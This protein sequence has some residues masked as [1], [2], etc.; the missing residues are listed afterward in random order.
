M[1]RLAAMSGAQAR[2]QSTET[3]AV[4]AQGDSTEEDAARAHA[5]TVA[6]GRFAIVRRLGEGAQ[7]TTL[8]AVDKRDGRLVAIKRFAVRGAK[9]WKDVELAE[10]EAR[11]LAS[12]SHPSLPAY[13]EHFEEDGCLYL[14]MERVDGESVRALQAGGQRFTQEDVVA[15]LNQAAD[16]L[17]YLHGHAPPIIHRDIKP[18]NVIRR[19]NGD[20]AIVD[21]GSVRD[22]LKPEGGSTV[23][24]TFGY[25]APEQF[26]GRAQPAS[27]VYAVGATAL[28]MLTARTPDQLPHHGLSI[29]VRGALSGQVAPA[30]V[31]TLVRMLE[32]NPDQRPLRLRPLLDEWGLSSQARGGAASPAPRR[33]QER[34]GLRRRQGPGWWLL[35]SPIIVTL[36]LVLLTIVSVVSWA[37]LQVALPL[38]FTVLSVVLGRRARYAARAAG[39]A[40]KRTRRALARA[41]RAVREQADAQAAHRHSARVGDTAVAESAAAGQPARSAEG[42]VAPSPRAPRARSERGRANRVRVESSP[43]AV[44][45]EEELEERDRS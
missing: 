13:I 1:V 20:Y 34:R 21:F 18:G 40:G 39:R 32:P 23:V 9:E 26:Q 35:E 36:L 12:L 33:R 25:M 19:P 43:P 4:A 38:V 5:E 6:G 16:T 2:L 41:R 30:L 28:S 8:E 15:F 17:D 24:G 44:S 10:R 14:V 27:D 11:V 29:D 45:E 37:V 42:P 3:G 31:E 7:G 22:N